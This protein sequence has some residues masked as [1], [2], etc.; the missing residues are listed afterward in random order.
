VHD[1]RQSGVLHS[2][3]D[4][5]VQL[6]ATPGGVVARMLTK[7]ISEAFPISTGQLGHLAVKSKEHC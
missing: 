2:E 1:N 7:R 4:E 6:L 5:T 3:G